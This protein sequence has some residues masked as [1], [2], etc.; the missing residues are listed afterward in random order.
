MRMDEGSRLVSLCRAPR[1]EEAAAEAEAAAEGNIDPA[2][3]EE[4][5]E[6]LVE[7]LTE[8]G[9]ADEAEE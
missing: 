1:E 2:A 4:T 9:F 6:E 3:G 5:D 8:A 7:E